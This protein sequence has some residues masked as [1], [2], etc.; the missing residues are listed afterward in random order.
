MPLKSAVWVRDEAVGCE[1][2]GQDS[3]LGLCVRDVPHATGTRMPGTRSTTPDWLSWLLKW[4]KQKPKEHLSSPTL[5]QL[6]GS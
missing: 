2:Q 4:V 3:R 1:V 6:C 5:S